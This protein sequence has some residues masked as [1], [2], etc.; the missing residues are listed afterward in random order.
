[1]LLFKFMV[2]WALWTTTH[3][4]GFGEMHALSAFGMEHQKFKDTL[5]VVI[6]Y[7]PWEPDIESKYANGGNIFCKTK[8]M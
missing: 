4:N 5:S 6:Y 3:W 8:Y 7:A 2:E 1:M